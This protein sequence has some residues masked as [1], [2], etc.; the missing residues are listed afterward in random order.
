[1]TPCS[2]SV[3]RAINLKQAEMAKKQ[4]LSARIRSQQGGSA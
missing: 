2:L 3:S 1:M 4:Q